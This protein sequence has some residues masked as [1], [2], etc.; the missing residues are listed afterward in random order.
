M[1]PRMR[2]RAF[3]AALAALGIATVSAF[4]ALPQQSGNVDLATQANVVAVGA[5]GDQLGHGAVPLGDVNGD[6]IGDFALPAETGGGGAGAAY[7]LF[8][9]PNQGTIDLASL[10]SGGF[11]IDAAAPTDQLTGS[12]AAE[13]VG[14]AGDVNGDGLADIVVGASEAANNGNGSGSAWVVFGKASSTPVN[15]ATLGS[16][17]FRI[18]GAAA[19]DNLGTA[20]AGAGDVNGDSKADVIVGATFAGPT[21]KGAA[22]VVFGKSDS[23][24]VAMAT[25]GSAGFAI[26]GPTNNANAGNSVAGGRDVNGDGVS[27][28][29]VGA[30]GSNQAWVVF[31]KGSATAVDLSALGAQGFRMSGGGSETGN[32]VGLAGDMNGDGRAEAIVAARFAGNNGR[33]S[34]GSVYA[35]FGRTETTDVD[36]STFDANGTAGFRVD[37]AVNQAQ[38]GRSV[39][40]AG[41]FN[42]DGRGDFVVGSLGTENLGRTGSGSASV[43]FGKASPD[44]IDLATP[45]SAAIRADGEASDLVGRG[46][47]G[48]R[49]VNG[50]NRPDVLIGSTSSNK[51]RVLYGFGTTAFSYPTAQISV[52]NESP[53]LDP[54]VPTGVKR[55]GLATFTVNAALPPGMALD[56]A[57]GTISGKWDGTG[58][59][60]GEYTVTM[61]D[62]AGTATAKVDI[63]LTFLD[64]TPLPPL[65]VT[66]P[67]KNVVRGTKAA[68]TLKGTTRGDLIHA[69]AGNDKVFGGAGDD[70]L[71]GQAGNDTLSGGAGKDKLDGGKGK[72][73]LKGGPG[74]D[75]FIGGAGNDT[76]NSKDGRRETVNC[77]KGRDRV[78]AD[79]RDKLKGCERRT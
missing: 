10:G 60:S 63:H 33:T 48:G 57:T 42:D 36:L 28:V 6:G 41:D 26:T 49:D 44:P 51:V 17:G 37:G 23:S 35:V 13:G 18:D 78:K 67:C 72:D 30:S 24:T 43:V 62:L 53:P 45:L 58:G 76:I 69:G 25:L 39:F 71:Y 12:F 31:G 3:F 77:G 7:V 68:N 22:Y 16:G 75:T 9:T 66:G 14:A 54:I 29:V 21:D 1:A 55:T 32:S 19:N 50:D 70:C 61:T 2:L 34:S 46:V 64:R 4:A 47:G 79:K 5:T 73:K 11:R 65:P 27:D 52:T 74:T 56:P 40:D 15:L 59:G 20:V 38:T 8:G